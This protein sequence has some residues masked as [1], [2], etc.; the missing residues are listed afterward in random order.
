MD[1]RNVAI[2]AHVDHGKTTLVDAMLKQ[3][4]TFRDN[5][6]EMT[7]TTILDSNELERE[8]GITILAKNTAVQYKDTKINIIDT[9]GHADFGGEVERVLNM[10]DGAVLVVDSAE[11]PLPQTKFVLQ[12]AIENGLKL[13]VV[14]NK[15]DKKLAEPEKT[16]T[17]VEDVFLHVATED[18]H[19]DYKVIYAVGRSGKSWDH[20]PTPAEL[21]APGSLESLFEMILSEVPSSRGDDKAPFQMLISTLERNAY[22]GKL[23]IGRIQ[24]GTVRL[25]DT[26]SL[27]TPEKVIG[28]S[29]IE[30]MFVSK[31]LEKV[32]VNEAVS[33]D[34]VALAG[35]KE[36]SIGQTVTDPTVQE[37]LPIITVTEP[38]LRITIG[39]N[40]SPLAGREGKFVTSRQLSERLLQEKE[41][42]LGLRIEEQSD[43]VGFVV[44]GRGELHLAVLIETMRRESY[45]MEVSRPQVILKEVHGQKLEPFDEV[46]ID[47]PDE[48]IGTVSGE[49]G[50]RRATVTQMT[51]NGRGDTRIVMEISER[52]L[53]GARTSLLTETRGTLLMS[54]VFLEYRPVVEE[55]KR[56]R[57][58]ALVASEA[59]TSAN[60]GLQNAQER[61]VTFIGAGEATYEGMIVGLN[62]REQDMRVNVNKVKESSN[63]RSANKDMRVQLTPP[64]RYSLEQALDFLADDEL[65]EVVPSALRLRK[66]WLTT[67]AEARAKKGL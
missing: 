51:P 49:F 2:I 44:S 23:S 4:H 35:I 28:N 65:L 43:G 41:T 55:F 54:A 30:K 29:R 52:N 48:F 34:I 59:G 67:E 56:D 58:G 66:K 33:G 26:V 20:M 7:Q 31:G 64:V 24:R 3:T 39:P 18:K 37:A 60:F 22:L 19:L 36:L 50:K 57:N 10:A 46:T 17:A 40:T 8:K 5:Q 61:G 16:M 9:P 42:N 62:S 25:G 15:I 14:I 13:I 11:G 53:L 63:V 45:E 47:I 27:V 32:P 1:I 6:A 38:T 12:K 21:E